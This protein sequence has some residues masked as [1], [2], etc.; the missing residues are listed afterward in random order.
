MEILRCLGPGFDF[1]K[2]VDGLFFSIFDSGR[3][4]FR[5]RRWLVSV[6]NE[7]TYIRLFFQ[8]D[9]YNIY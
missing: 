6:G 8:V 3:D 5:K 2:W 1:K 4:G 7:V 9:D